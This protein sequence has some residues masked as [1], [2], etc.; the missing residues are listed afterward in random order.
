ML[1]SFDCL[2]PWNG[3]DTD[4]EEGMISITASKLRDRDYWKVLEKDLLRLNFTTRLCI[5]N[6]DVYAGSGLKFYQYRI[7]NHFDH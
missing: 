2:S 1:L 6:I 7:A 3:Y 5:I 4:D